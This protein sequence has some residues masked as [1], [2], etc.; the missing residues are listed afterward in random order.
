MIITD[1]PGTCMEKISL[2]IVGPLPKTKTGNE[3]ILTMQCL[4]SKFSMGAASPNTLTSTI[5]DAF[6]QK[7]ICLFG[8]PKV[9]LTDLG[10]NFVSALMAAVAKRLRLKKIQTSAYRPQSNAS[11]ER[12][13]HVLAQYLKQYVTRDSEWDE[14]IDLAIFAYNTSK[15]ESTGYT[16][17]ELVFGKET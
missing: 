17:F 2:D 14:W 5:A 11:V 6:I 3:Y 9:V 13:H 1:T 12:S 15:H 4:F 7:C 16:P 10:K 8:S